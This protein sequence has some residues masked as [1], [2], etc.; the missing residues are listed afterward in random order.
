MGVLYGN[1]LAAFIMI[2]VVLGGGAAW[3]TGRAIANTWGSLAVAVLYMIPLAAA[4]RFLHFALAKGD[5][6]SLHYYLVDLAVLTGLAA[7]SFAVNRASLMA[8]QYPWL[9]R[10]A[11]LFGLIEIDR[12]TGETRPEH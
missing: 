11:G 1:S 8:R 3:L 4:A 2:T 12:P 6:L 10:R 5:L 7:L 9:Y